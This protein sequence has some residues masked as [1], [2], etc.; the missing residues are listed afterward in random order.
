MEIIKAMGNSK[1]QL[2]SIAVLIFAILMVVSLAVLVIV[3][4]GY[5]SITQS[6][7]ITSS[8]AN[9][10]ALLRQSASSFAYGSGSAALNTLFKY[11]Y[12]LSLRKTNLISNFSEYMQYLMVNGSLPNV[13]AGSS[14]A[15]VIQKMMGNAT[16][17]SYNSMI[18]SVTGAGSKSIKISETKPHIYQS[19]P[20]SIAI[21]YDEYVNINTSSGALSFT[22][23]VNASISI[24]NT[25]DLFY[26][27]QGVY[28][29]VKPGNLN[30]LVTL[31]GN[32]Y[33]SS[34][35]TIGYVYG[36]AY[37][38]SFSSTCS[39]VPS[40]L[41]SPPYSSQLIIVDA[42]SLAINGC[43]TYG[44][45]ITDNSVSSPP[46]LPYLVTSTATIQSLQTGQHILLY[47]PSLAVLNV[48][49]LIDNVSSGTYFSSPFAPSFSQRASGNIQQQS[50]SG[51]FTLSGLANRQ[52]AQFNGASSSIITTPLPTSATVNTVISAWFL[53]KSSTSGQVI[54]LLGNNGGTN[55]YGIYIGGSPT[56]CASGTLAIL[57]AGINWICTGVAYNPN[58]W[59]D[60]ALVSLPSS[61]NVVYE[62]FLNGILVYTS[63][64]ESLPNAPSSSMLIGS[65]NAGRTFNG[66]ISNVQVY[67]D[68]LSSFQVFQLYQKGIDG[69]PILGANV[70]GWWP[71]NG[72]SNDYS[73]NGNNGVQSQV[74][75]GLLPAYVRDSAISGNATATV[76]AMP[77]LANCNTAGLCAGNFLQHLYLSNQ[78]LSIGNSRTTAAYFSGSQNN[79]I[80]M[81]NP[82]TINQIQYGYTVS[83]WIY[84]TKVISGDAQAIFKGVSNNYDDFGLSLNGPG[85]DGICGWVNGICGSSTCSTLTLVNINNWYNVVA[86][87]AAGTTTYAAIYVNGNFVG[88]CAGTTS[89]SGTSQPEIGSGSDVNGYSTFFQGLISNVQLYNASLSSSQISQ[90]Y[91]GGITGTPV[92]PSNVMGW[93]PLNGNAN[94]YSGHGNN[95]IPNNIA[96]QYI[97]VFPPSGQSS[98]TIVF[99]QLQGGSTNGEWQTLGF[100]ASP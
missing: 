98:N 61:G 6:S 14:A 2:M 58:Q 87:W 92:V 16:F 93:W 86:V 13:V 38:L 75:F 23:P 88:N 4:I 31:I 40:P 57:Q 85:T 56:S 33:A 7:V 27:Q 95:G 49:N 46:P 94:D 67:G 72:N 71:L 83:A 60:I 80:E 51:I 79:Y 15:S 55:G 78:P 9:Y 63:P 100:G 68:S 70:L 22:I 76:N 81:S 20:Y 35:N 10:G 44:G 37:N 54:V 69:L 53:T 48:T 8:S 90:L 21:Q 77:G 45:F 66:L 36:T 42:N 32:S 17:A 89:Y 84:T 65:D 73:G 1:G 97:S 34:G 12:N 43:S 19:N 18:S 28:R 25:P 30:N 11:E 52:A 62:L 29:L 99:P 41:N 24:N 91:N 74:T 3:G 5:D 39:S 50:S 59:Y 47:G 64:S 96:F 82:V 26:A